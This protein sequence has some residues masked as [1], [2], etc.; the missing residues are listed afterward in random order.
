MQL[1]N[2]NLIGNAI[3]EV[4]Y[5]FDCFFKLN[6]MWCDHLKLKISIYK[7]TT[8]LKVPNVSQ[9]RNEND[10]KTFSPPCQ[11]DG[12]FLSNN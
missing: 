1:K 10:S 2:V 7:D 12:R 4:F 8:D 5:I 6:F 3:Q 9:S 11:G